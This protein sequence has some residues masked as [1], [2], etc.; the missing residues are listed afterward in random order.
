MTQ[1]TPKEHLMERKK[2]K[3]E[4]ASTN[5]AIGFKDH[6]AAIHHKN[7]SKLDR[8]SRQFPCQVGFALE[9]YGNIADYQQWKNENNSVDGG[10]IQCEQ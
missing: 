3:E 7:S 5:M 6:K 9:S 4:T 8:L 10:S 1:I 2:Q